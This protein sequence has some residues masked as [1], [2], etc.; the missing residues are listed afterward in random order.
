MA[1]DDRIRFCGKCQQNVYN[2]ESLNA[3]E[4]RALVQ[5]NEGRVCVRLRRRPD[6]TV[7]TRDCWYAVRRARE[8]LLATAMGVAVAAAGFWGGVG[9][10]SRWFGARRAPVAACPEPLLPR[11]SLPEIPEPSEIEGPGWL[12]RGLRDEQGGRSR[13]PKVRRKP[14]PKPIQPRVHEDITMGAMAITE[15]RD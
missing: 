3:E 9:V 10:L 12:S 1:G 14:R 7:I 4:V 5:R 13:P 15:G 11:A 2:V 6:G 8:R